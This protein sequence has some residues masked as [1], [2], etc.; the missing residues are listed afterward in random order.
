MGARTEWVLPPYF[1]VVVVLLFLGSSICI[2]RMTTML[3][4]VMKQ[5][6]MFPGDGGM[7][8]F[9]R[10]RLTVADQATTN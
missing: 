2:V 3:V 4:F 1:A 10:F 6:E 5:H 7:P 8:T 9:M